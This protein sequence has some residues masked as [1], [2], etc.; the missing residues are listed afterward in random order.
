MERHEE[1]SSL[2]RTTALDLAHWP[3]VVGTRDYA[4]SK[5]YNYVPYLEV[6]KELREDHPL[7]EQPYDEASLHSQPGSE[8]M[9]PTIEP[10]ATWK[11]IGKLIMQKSPCSLRELKDYFFPN[12]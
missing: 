2:D 8:V 6:A 7:P 5:I 4:S 1:L 9:P 10:P 12:L 11:H 3:T